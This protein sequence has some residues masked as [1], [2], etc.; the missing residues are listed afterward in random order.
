LLRCEKKRIFADAKREEIEGHRE[1]E[2]SFLAFDGTVSP[3]IAMR[4]TSDGI[5]ITAPKK[6][7]QHFANLFG[8]DRARYR[9]I[10]GVGCGVSWFFILVLS[11]CLP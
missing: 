9:P 2:P 10:L 1:K 4:V 11:S 5:E 6:K 3:N 8:A 7:Q